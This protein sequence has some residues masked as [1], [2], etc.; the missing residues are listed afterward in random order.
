MLQVVGCMKKV[1]QATKGLDLESLQCTVY[2]TFT[3]SLSLMRCM[4]TVVDWSS[5]V[6]RKTS[7][8]P[9]MSYVS[10]KRKTPKFCV[11]FNHLPS[12]FQ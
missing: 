7:G 6:H 11:S 3:F 5:W 1:P 8:N 10:H 9:K 4:L 12:A 2:S